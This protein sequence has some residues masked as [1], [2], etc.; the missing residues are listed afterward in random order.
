VDEVL[1][2]V[3]VEERLG[4]V[5]DLPDDD[6]GD[7]DRIAL[8]VVD[9]ELLALEVADALRDALLHRE[10]IHPAQPGVADGADVAAEERDDARLV[11][12]HGEEARQDQQSG[13]QREH[14]EQREAGLPRD[15]RRDEQRDCAEQQPDP[16]EQEGQARARL[17]LLLGDRLGEDRLNHGS[18][19]REGRR[20]A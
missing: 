2:V 8:A 14:A 15:A 4:G 20:P 16:E 19:P 10:G 18:S 7:L 17:E 1:V 13:Q 11:R 9:L 6:A 5:D 12:L 3:D